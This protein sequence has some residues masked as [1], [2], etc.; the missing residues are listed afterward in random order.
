MTTLSLIVGLREERFITFRVHLRLAFWIVSCL[1]F[2]FSFFFFC[3]NLNSLTRANE[4]E[5]YFFFFLCGMT[6][7]ADD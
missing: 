1:I 2:W 3:G 4:C 6:R 5:C 7:L